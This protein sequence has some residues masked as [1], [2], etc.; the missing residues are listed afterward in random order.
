[1]KL[2]KDNYKGFFAARLR[3]GILTWMSVPLSFSALKVAMEH[4]INPIHE[5]LSGSTKHF[6]LVFLH[7]Q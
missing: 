4:T 3:L 7:M 2:T 1:M 6:L 5:A